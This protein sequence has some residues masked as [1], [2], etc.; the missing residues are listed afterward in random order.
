MLIIIIMIIIIIIIRLHIKEINFNLNHIIIN[1]N[2]KD[3]NKDL[4]LS[5][6]NEILIQ[7]LLFHMKNI[8]LMKLNKIIFL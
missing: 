3:K 8:I 7:L 1:R 2:L 4:A 5:W 6:I